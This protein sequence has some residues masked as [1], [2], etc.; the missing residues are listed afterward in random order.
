[1]RNRHMKRATNSFSINRLARLAVFA[2]AY[3]VPSQAGW[4]ASYAVVIGISEYGNKLSLASNEKLQFPETDAEA[5]Y[6]ILLSEEGGGI[7]PANIRLLLGRDATRAEVTRVIED[8]LPSAATANDTVFIYFS[9]HGHYENGA[10]Y[11]LTYDT[12]RQ[13]I[14]GTSYPMARLQRALR[15]TIRAKTKV[16]FTDACHSGVLN[17][18]P[19]AV[20]QLRQGL[21]GLDSRTFSLA[22]SS[23]ENESLEIVRP[24]DRHTVFGAALISGLEG[25]ADTNCDGIVTAAELADFVTIRTSAASNQRQIPTK[26]M[27]AALEKTALARYRPRCSG[28]SP[29]AERGSIVVSTKGFECK[30]QRE[31]AVVSIDGRIVGT[32]CANKLLISSLPRG[33]HR[34]SVSGTGWAAEER[35]VQ[36]PAQ[37]NANQG[38]T[39]VEL[40][41]RRLP[42]PPDAV[43][44]A[45][46]KAEEDY[47]KGGEK[48]YQKAIDEL[49]RAA[50][51]A[52]ENPE[53]SYRKGLVY[54][55]SGEPALAVKA[56]SQALANDPSYLAAR[57]L[58]ADLQAESPNGAGQAIRT[59]LQ[60]REMIR[61]DVLA[62]VVLS[63]A[64]QRAGLCGESVR[65]A[66]YASS[67]N[68]S[69]KELQVEPVV[70][71][72]VSLKM[73]AD[74]LPPGDPSKKELYTK[75]ADSFQ[76]ALA[77]LQ[78]FK[79]G[80][81]GE[82]RY[83]ALGLFGVGWKYEALKKEQYEKLQVDISAGLCEVNGQ[84]GRTCEAATA[85]RVW[86]DLRTK[87]AEA[88]FRLTANLIKL[89][90]SG[91]TCSGQAASWKTACES[92]QQL[93]INRLPV[94]MQMPARTL[95]A[96][97]QTKVSCPLP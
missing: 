49:D 45:I 67:L 25:L 24:Q 33:A 43:A 32:I 95:G 92:M 27:P 76:Q 12:D 7:P 61:N 42:K 15:D 68:A 6:A 94:P 23:A 69:T 66:R 84:L 41:M 58:Q 1:M 79:S 31:A 88:Q 8:W 16:L 44:K 56:L 81:G 13:N 70:E 64:Y 63:R 51:S 46:Q 39:P 65:W 47:F 93:E 82:L 20:S 14:A 62:S 55:V 87:D 19:S 37:A 9:G 73:C 96:L 18:P 17:Q 77:R 21:L 97:I 52:A 11:L 5:L 28:T 2:A 22:A 50:P 26:F 34:V 60:V 83:E 91:G 57:I 85:C 89:A 59:L 71:Q 86:R 54:K 78:L 35:T 90:E 72:S 40:T 53:I 74:G 80:A 29:A 38:D 36:I 75:A 30:A 48:R 10:G 3:L 4:C